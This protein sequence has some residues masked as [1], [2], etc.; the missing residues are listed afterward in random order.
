M[1]AHAHTHTHTPTFTM[2]PLAVV[3]FLNSNTK[4]GDFTHTQGF[5]WRPILILEVLCCIQSK[6]L[7]QYRYFPPEVN[8]KVYNKWHLF[9]VHVQC[10][11]LSKDCSK[12]V[13]T[14]LGLSFQWQV[15]YC[16]Y[17]HSESVGVYYVCMMIFISLSWPWLP[18]RQ[19]S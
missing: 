11:F 6:S 13:R 7:G 2:F 9:T 18:R 5:I 10:C 4:Q 17:N 8:P 12:H 16:I 1:H 19:H 3:V 14:F 15:Y